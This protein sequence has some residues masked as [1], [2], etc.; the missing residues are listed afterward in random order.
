MSLIQMSKLTFFKGLNCQRSAAVQPPGEKN[1]SVFLVLAVFNKFSY[2][3]VPGV[4][5]KHESYSLLISLQKVISFSSFWFILQRLLQLL[6]SFL[7]ESFQINLLC[8][9]HLL[10]YS[11]YLKVFFE[12][13]MDREN[14]NEKSKTLESFGFRISCLSVIVFF[15]LQMTILHCGIQS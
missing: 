2:E 6:L 11:L 12:P 14:Q 10:Q 15:F 4:F 8:W 5:R 3:L 13:R 9:I 7:L 1:K